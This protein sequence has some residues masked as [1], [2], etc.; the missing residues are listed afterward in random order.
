MKKFTLILFSILFF[1]FVFQSGAQVPVWWQTCGG[2]GG[3]FFFF[4]KKNPANDNEFYV[5]CDMSEMFHST[6][7]GNSYTQLHFTKL[8]AM[9]VSTYEFTNN[10]NIAYSNYND[11]NAG[12]PVKTTDGGATWNQLPGFNV[13]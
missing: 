5:A 11:G 6:D 13:G 8:P 9:N 4:P 12:Y 1:S 2:G 7:F 3:G 10:A